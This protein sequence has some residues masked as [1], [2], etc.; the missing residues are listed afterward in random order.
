MAEGPELRRPVLVTAALWILA[1]AMVAGVTVGLTRSFLHPPEV[2]GRRVSST[3]TEV[4]AV[5]QL[6]VLV[7]QLVLLWLMARRRRWAYIVYLV[8]TL[9]GLLSLPITALHELTAGLAASLYFV[10]H[11]AAVLGG[12][13]LLL[14]AKSRSWFAGQPLPEL[15]A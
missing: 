8:L 7:F 4:T 13:V 11:G 9:L 2:H 12:V 15:R 1:V 6:A 14:T 3:V 10:L 5:L